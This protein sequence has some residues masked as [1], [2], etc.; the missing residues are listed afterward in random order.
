M[1]KRDYLIVVREHPNSDENCYS[2]HHAAYSINDAILWFAKQR[3]IKGGNLN[4]FL[5]EN[6]RKKGCKKKMVFALPYWNDHEKM[7]EINAIK[8]ETAAAGNRLPGYL[9][10]YRQQLEPPP[11]D[12][13]T[14][15]PKMKSTP[16][17]LRRP[18]P[19]NTPIKSEEGKTEKKGLT[20]FAKKL[21]YYARLEHRGEGDDDDNNK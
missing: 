10:K 16:E 9:D 19:V 3:D 1:A 20:D 7:K 13:E 8:R 12:P 18:L 14:N 2:Q 17:Q 21:L 4:R 5:D 11:D 6:G 15:H